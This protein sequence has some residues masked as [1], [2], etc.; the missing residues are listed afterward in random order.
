MRGLCRGDQIRNAICTWNCF[1]WRPDEGNFLLEFSPRV[2]L[3]GFSAGGRL[4]CSIGLLNLLGARIQPQHMIKVSRQAKRQL[5]GPAADI[6]RNPM[7]CA[8]RGEVSAQLIRI[9]R[10]E[11]RIRLTALVKPVEG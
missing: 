8:Q 9:V 4:M 5:S 1:G 3:I 11:G 7:R 2:G 6:N 10:T